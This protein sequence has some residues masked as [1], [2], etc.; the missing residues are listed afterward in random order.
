M[1]KT[2]KTTPKTIILCC[3]ANGRAVVIGTVDQDPVPG[4]AVH[5]RDARMV[6][7]WDAECGG[8]LGLAAR[9]PR[10]K[11]RITHAVPVVCETV[12]QEWIALTAEAAE[13]VAAWPAC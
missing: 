4:K 5:L 7:Y 12:W 2:T 11:T 8:L 6:L 10:G 1:K 9:G 3:G 13:E